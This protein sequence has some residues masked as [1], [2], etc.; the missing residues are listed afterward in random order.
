MNIQCSKLRFFERLNVK[1]YV[2]ERHT[3][4]FCRDIKGK[5]FAKDVNL[6]EV[7]IRY[8][9]PRKRTCLVNVCLQVI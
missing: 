8:G 9:S 1:E 3:R 4:E 7:D 5:F 2:D 6:T